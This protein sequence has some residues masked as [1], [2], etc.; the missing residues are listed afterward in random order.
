MRRRL[1]VRQHYRNMQCE[2]QITHY[3]IRMPPAPTKYEVL[4]RRK[5]NM[6]VR[7]A[8]AAPQAMLPVKMALSG[9]PEAVEARESLNKY[10]ATLSA[11]VAEAEATT[12]SR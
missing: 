1:R 8:P 6:N 4:M 3:C 11:A 9:D 5:N 2:A 12:T 10:K 7:P